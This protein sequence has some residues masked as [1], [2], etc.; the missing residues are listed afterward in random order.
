MHRMRLLA[1]SSRWYEVVLIRGMYH[2]CFT[3]RA[4]LVDGMEYYWSASQAVVVHS[5]SCRGLLGMIL[6]NGNASTEHVSIE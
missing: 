1:R 6:K 4:L 3:C 2:Y 5:P